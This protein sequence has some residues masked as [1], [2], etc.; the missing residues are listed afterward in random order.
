MNTEDKTKQFIAGIREIAGAHLPSSLA[1]T[2]ARMLA[3]VR[4]WPEGGKQAPGFLDQNHELTSAEWLATLDAMARAWERRASR[5]ESPFARSAREPALGPGGL[6][7]LR[8]LILGYLEWDRRHA[9]VPRWLLLAM[10]DLADEQTLFGRGERW[11]DPKLRELIV[12]IAKDTAKKRVYC[13]YDSAAGVAIE[14]AA[15]RT[16][17]TLDVAPHFAPLCA[18][19]AAAADLPLRVRA[20]NPLALARADL[21]GSP[22]MPDLYDVS[23]VLPPFNVR[24]DP[25]KWDELGTGLPRG[26]TSEAAGVTL[27]LARGKGAAICMVAPSFLF[28]TS[29]A[30]QV[31]KE[32]AIR[33]FGLGAVV[34]LPRGTTG[35]ASISAALLL[36]QP[37]GRASGKRRDEDVFLVNAQAGLEQAEFSPPEPARLARL[38]ANRQP[39]DISLS[40]PVEQL[41][42]NAFNLS[43]ERYVLDAEAKRLRELTA[44]AVTAPLEALVELYRPQAIPS[45]KEDLSSAETGLA[46][47]G[48]ADLDEAG[49]VRSAGKPLVIAQ[50]AALQLR[51]ARLEIGDVL[52]VIKGSVGKVGFVREIPNGA[53][54]LASQSFV[55]LRLRPHAALTDPR[56][57][58]RFLSSA[59]GQARLQSLRVGVAVPGLKMEDVRQLPIV[60]PDKDTQ[61]KVT[62][63]IEALFALQDRIAELRAEL[64]ER[65]RL[66]WP[67]TL[68][69]APSPQTRSVLRG[70]EGAPPRRKRTS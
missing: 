48:V 49:V 12:A 36:F 14:L 7:R 11:L 34:G 25:E 46:E 66:I 17:V 63:E 2:V 54:W 37:G 61:S 33:G 68:G 24:R 56:V 70:T 30:D 69:K 19:L 42:E 28:Q 1:L 62:D 29:K 52:L 60:V 35:A 45:G 50:N 21:D 39:S 41:A 8:R 20:G 47:V 38:I 15:D 23:I 40:V 26:A 43:V 10:L 64:T 18:C 5:Q 9:Q 51:R 22:L 55:I 32:Q 6:E 4:L 44:Q 31:F 53:T 67:E 3:A 13:A 16:D 57:L 65:Q 59:S 58:F 27:A